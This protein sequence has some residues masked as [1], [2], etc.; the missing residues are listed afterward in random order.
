MPPSFHLLLIPGTCGLALCRRF[1]LWNR[2]SRLGGTSTS[3]SGV[4]S[5]SCSQL[6]FPP[7][8]PLPINLPS[9][10]LLFGAAFTFFSGYP[11]ILDF[12]SAAPLVH[13]AGYMHVLVIS[14]FILHLAREFK[15][16]H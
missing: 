7:S 15:S 3:K 2:A 5:L 11:C 6:T 9:Q 16:V 1:L 12:P 4:R 8:L 13:P 14:S 10:L